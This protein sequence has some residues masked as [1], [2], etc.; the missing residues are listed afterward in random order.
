MVCELYLNE[1]MLYLVIQTE[2]SSNKN[3]NKYKYVYIFF[4]S[5]NLKKGEEEMWYMR[6]QILCNSK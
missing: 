3:I 2:K 5:G 6:S 1:K 4:E